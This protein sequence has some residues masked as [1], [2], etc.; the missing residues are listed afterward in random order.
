[1]FFIS[2]ATELQEHIL[3][4]MGKRD[5]L[6]MGTTC[7]QVADFVRSSKLLKEMW[8][9]LLRRMMYAQSRMD[10]MP[11]SDLKEFKRAHSNLSTSEVVCRTIEKGRK[12][13]GEWTQNDAM[14]LRRLEE[15]VER[16]KHKQ[17][18]AHIRQQRESGSTPSV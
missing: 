6:R 7:S 5:V 11:R 2:L 14:K 8:I 18:Y 3:E 16:L 4:Y 17:R 15:H 1:M 13:F 9:G 12:R 10:W